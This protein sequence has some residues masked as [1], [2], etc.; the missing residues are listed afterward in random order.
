MDEVMRI[1]LIACL[2]LVACGQSTTDTEPAP[3]VSATPRTVFVHLFEWSWPD[4]AKE[5][6]DFLGPNGYAAVQVSPPQ[7]HH[8]GPEWYVRYQPVSYQL[9]SRGGNREQFID[10]VERCANAGVDIYVDAVINHMTG[11]RESGVG[12]AGTVYG[13]YSYP[14]LYD[15]DDF[16]HCGRH[17]NDDIADYNDKWEMQYCELVNLADLKTSS[18]KVQE[19]LAA[20]L[21]DLLSIGVAGFRIDAAKHMPIEDLE[22]IMSMVGPEYFVFLET[23]VADSSV[24]DRSAYAQ[25]G[26]LTEFQFE[27]RVADAMRHGEI[28]KLVNLG[29]EGG[30]LPS[31]DAVVFV[32]NHDSQR[33]DHVLTYK[34]PEHYILANV[35]MLGH[36]YGYPKVMSSY[37]FS[38]RNT[39]APDVSPVID[40]TCSNGWVCE[41]RWPEIAAMVEFRNAT[42]GA[43]LTNW[44]LHESGAFSFGRE[45]RGQVVINTGGEA[46]RVTVETGLPDGDYCNRLITT[47]CQ[48]FSIRDGRFTA[49]LSPRS[50]VVLRPDET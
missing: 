49:T 30:M 17:G 4:I 47:D 33:G 44:S 32:D 50:A 13:E 22:A 10:M 31:S 45:D 37:V 3:G 42:H 23:L 15:Y 29:E 40:G 18:T 5:C 6:E 24:I 41:H 43:A 7:E 46:V 25:I 26:A 48:P 38:E 34:E 14:P 1:L 16:N 11:V 20:Y 28:D 8:V 12:T 2:F 9:V 36:P 19:T 39:G 35:F 27:G 21:N